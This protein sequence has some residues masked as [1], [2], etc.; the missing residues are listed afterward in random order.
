M[1]F[2][3]RSP[4]SVYT[5]AA[6]NVSAAAACM[7][8]SPPIKNGTSPAAAVAAAAATSSTAS[9]PPPSTGYYASLNL[10]RAAAGY[11]SLPPPPPPPP[12]PPH[13]ATSPCFATQHS[14]PMTTLT[15]KNHEPSP[16]LN[17]PTTSSTQGIITDQNPRKD[18]RENAS[19]TLLSPASSPPSPTFIHEEEASVPT[20]ESESV[21]AGATESDDGK[22]RSHPTPTIP[23]P[24]VQQTESQACVK[25]SSPNP[26][27]HDE[28]LSSHRSDDV[29]SA[30]FAHARAPHT[31]HALHASPLTAAPPAPLS[32]PSLF[33]LTALPT[34]PLI[35]AA[36]HASFE[37]SVREPR[38]QNNNK[39][40]D[41]K[42][43]M[44]FKCHGILT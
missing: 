40:H 27:S 17:T 11:S 21:D 42:L 33:P 30:S 41:G 39:Y 14:K 7:Q 35:P 13:G 34:A 23:S 19:P 26:Y 16:P 3:L 6:A 8:Q 44:Q 9:A 5:A 25:S 36:S 37:A 2:S 18:D 38:S 15:P 43:H 4:L 1:I 29:L 24:L 32:E 31:L 28:T 10:Q 12:L 20:Q 22:E